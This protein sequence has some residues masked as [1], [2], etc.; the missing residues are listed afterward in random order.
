MKRI[1]LLGGMSWE[2][3]AVYCGLINK[4]GAHATRRP[5]LMRSAP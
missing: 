2:S 4:G 3:T 5:L 1:G